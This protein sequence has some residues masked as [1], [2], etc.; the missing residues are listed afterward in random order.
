MKKLKGITAAIAAAAIAVS[1]AG[2]GNG[3]TPATSEPNP[4]TVPTTTVGMGGENNGKAELAVITYNNSAYADSFGDSISEAVKS[5]ADQ[6]NLKFESY[7]ADSQQTNS[8]LD[9]IKKAVDGGARL[10]FMNGSEFENAVFHAQELYS[11][12]DFVLINGTP[13][14]GDTAPVYRTNSNVVNAIFADEQLGYL[15]GYAAVCDG[16]KKL[17]CIGYTDNASARNYAYGFAQGAEDAA[18]AEKAS[19]ITI[20]NA[21][22]KTE[23]DAEQAK[24]TAD[25]W[26]KDGVQAVSVFGGKLCEDVI[27]A[28]KTNKG[29]VICTDSDEHNSDI[30]LVSAERGGAQAAEKLTGQ[31]YD[32]SFPGGQTVN[33]NAANDGIKL[34]MSKSTLKKFSED[35]Y[36][37][38][39]GKL[40]AGKTEVKN[41]DTLKSF[42]D[43]KLTAV[44]TETDS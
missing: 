26:Y 41:S 16:Y 27:D 20:K 29:K 36:K 37:E 25:K 9:T 15:C 34:N 14:N 12:V 23:G 19:G 3:N 1:L 39:F 30:V 31:F 40:A 17:G 2:C 21:M 7:S 11:D 8:Y 32:G 42:E 10:I 33:F 18:K 4:S 28:A 13:N 44:K 6:N 35:K 5:Y 38:V 43:L 22:L 24:Q